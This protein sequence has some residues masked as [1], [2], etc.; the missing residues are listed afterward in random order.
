MLVSEFKPLLLQSAN[1]L[2]HLLPGIKLRDYQVR[3]AIHIAT[4]DSQLLAFDTGLGKTI[5]I[6]A[7]LTA[8]KNMGKDL[9][10]VFLCPLAGMEQVAE[11]VRMHTRFRPV[12]LTGSEKG[13][14]T[15]IQTL[16]E[17]VDFVLCNYEA[18]DNPEV[19]KVLHEMTTREFFNTVVL[20]EAHVMANIYTSN[21]NFFI[22]TLVQ[23]IKYRYFLTATPIISKTEQYATLLAL[24]RNEI[25][26]LGSLQYRT[27]SGEF[28]HSRVP[29]LVQYKERE[30]GYKVELH[31]FPE[32][33]FTGTSYGTEVFKYTRGPNSADVE[34]KLR[35]L[36]RGQEGKLL[37]YSHLKTN[38]EYLKQVA[39]DEGRK[40]GIIS[41]DT[42]KGNAQERFNK[43]EL[44]CIIF[45]IPTELNLPADSIILY[46]WTS[47]A[48]QAIGRGIRSEKVEGY[49][50]HIFLTDT[51]KELSLFKNT[52]M[53]N[54][55][56][57]SESFGKDIEPLLELRRR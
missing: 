4:L 5:S 9:R 30:V 1:F 11:A 20:D 10:V 32:V 16:D 34:D 35:K 52:V 49:V 50:A 27:K 51:E 38:H 12:M 8:K 39:E 24:L 44:D 56:Y 41:G 22:G 14:D 55:I 13:L 36:I 57:L 26:D 45:S 21:R 15:F 31:R 23:K 46:D 40:V 6:L 25:H 37:I 48:H 53:K 2:E 3:A 7:G 43:G 42:K 29:H 33:K 28:A 47:M 19:L 17:A 54:S 18:I